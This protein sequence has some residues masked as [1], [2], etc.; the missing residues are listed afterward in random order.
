MTAKQNTKSSPQDKMIA[1]IQRE[2]LVKKIKRRVIAP[3]SNPSVSRAPLQSRAQATMDEILLAAVRILV[4]DGYDELNTNHIAEEAN[5]SVSTLYQYFTD[6]NAVLQ[7]L[8]DLQCQQLVSRF[9]QG[10]AEF[11]GQPLIEA[12]HNLIDLMFDSYLRKTPLFGLLRRQIPS[13]DLTQALDQALERI[14]QLWTFAFKIRQI[15]LGAMDHQT[16]GFLITN[17]TYGVLDTIQRQP[18]PDA[19][20]KV[21]QRATGEMILSLFDKHT[22]RSQS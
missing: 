10:V 16:V 13:S 17:M 1:R 20:E 18:I 22:Q 2:C 5:I 4:R 15:D 14:E 12:V 11:A 7:A 3:K 19:E 9:E 21:L 6:K 8:I